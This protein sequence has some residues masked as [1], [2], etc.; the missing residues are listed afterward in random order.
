MSNDAPPKSALELAMERLRRQD[1]AAGIERKVLTDEQKAAIAE[2]RSV[3]DARLAQADVMRQSR[4]RATFDPAAREV[5][6]GEYRHERE[7]L[8]SERDAKIERLRLS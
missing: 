7:Q 6:E 8:T 3:Y 4:L 1:E 5:I 2:V